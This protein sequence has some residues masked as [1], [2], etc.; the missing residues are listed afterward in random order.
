MKHKWKRSRLE[1]IFLYLYFAMLPF[2][3][4]PSGMPQ[5][6]DYMIIVWSA[7]SIFSFSSFIGARSAVGV[8][9]FLIFVFYIVVVSVLTNIQYFSRS[10]RLPVG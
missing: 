2:Y 4:F 10:R 6:S 5:I 1:K 7:I 9:F 8:Y 3:L